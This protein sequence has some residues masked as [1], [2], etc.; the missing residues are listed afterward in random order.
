M[1]TGGLVELFFF[2]M[3]LFFQVIFPM[4]LQGMPFFFLKGEI[5][6]PSVPSKLSDVF[7]QNQMSNEKTLGCLGYINTYIYI[8]I[9]IYI[10]DYTIH[11]YQNYDKPL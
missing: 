6:A 11:L 10:W 5:G 9:C 8:Y 2:P 7:G 3:D 4:K 1:W